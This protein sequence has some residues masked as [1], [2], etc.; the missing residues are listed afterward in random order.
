MEITKT[1]IQ[2]ILIIHPKV[3]EDERGYFFE[4]FQAQK[5]TSFG[6]KASFI[7][8][9]QSGSKKGVLRGLHYQIQKPQGKLIRVINGEVFDVAVDIRK[10]SPTYGKWIGTVLSSDNKIQIW[11]PPGFAHGF[12]VTSD[13]GEIVYK[14]TEVYAPEFERTIIWSDPDIGIKW[15]LSNVDPIISPK[16]ANGKFLRDAEI[17][18]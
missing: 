13:V 10:S 12:Y 16:D 18:D 11:I 9:N 4:V 17:Y 7:Q 5:Y 14:T 6:L 1:S 15:P 3:F 2:D 8:D